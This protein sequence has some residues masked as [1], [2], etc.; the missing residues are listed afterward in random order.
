M[1]PCRGPLSFSLFSLNVNFQKKFWWPGVN[2]ANI[3]RAAFALV[4]PKSAKKTVKLS[5]FIAVLGSARKK[6]AH[7]MLVKLTPG[8]LLRMKQGI[9]IRQS[10]LCNSTSSC[11]VLWL[12][13][14]CRSSSARPSKSRHREHEK[15]ALKMS[16][17]ILLFLLLSSLLLL[18]FFEWHYFLAKYF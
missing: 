2:F 12:S 3:L 4:G 18:I 7:R 11:S 17:S 15:F 8:G 10:Y 16:I 13:W 5:S 1:G 14:K 6:A 9:K